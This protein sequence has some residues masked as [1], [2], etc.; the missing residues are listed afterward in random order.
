VRGLGPGFVG[1]ERTSRVKAAGDGPAVGRARGADWQ[2]VPRRSRLQ[3]HL[4][5][6]GIIGCQHVPAVALEETGGSEGLDIL[7]D[8]LVVPS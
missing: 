2:D 5:R 4:R 6:D 1:R 8:A 7:M 3:A